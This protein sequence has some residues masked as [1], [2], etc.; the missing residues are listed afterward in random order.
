MN[1]FFDEFVDPFSPGNI[2][3]RAEHYERY[4]FAQRYCK[5][6]LPAKAAVLDI[7]CGNG[8]GSVTLA[9]AGY[10]VTGID[11]SER[12]LQ[13]AKKHT[14]E[15]TWKQMDL[16]ADKQ[17]LLKDIQAIICFEILEHIENPETI[18]KSC[19]QS[20]TENGLLFI[21]VPN[22]RYEPKKKGIAKNRF[23]KQLFSSER[24][25]AMVKEA[26]FTILSQ[27]G[28]PRANASYHDHKKW[29]ST[30]STLTS[31]VPR[32]LPLFSSQIAAVEDDPQEKSYS[33]FLICQ[34]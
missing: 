22:E 21:S 1:T 18:L 15:I 8:Y 30:L 34:K 7:G 27:L 4:R 6:N 10:I 25:R 29:V 14:E 24:L 3:I 28:Q 20:L 31:Y 17:S 2:V 32:L 16:E 5:E 33:L 11:L 9:K 26:G 13:K 23:H 19:Y 12:L